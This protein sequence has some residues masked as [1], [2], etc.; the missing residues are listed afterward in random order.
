MFQIV[1]T[2]VGAASVIPVSV[3]HT[4]MADMLLIPVPVVHTDI[5]LLVLKLPAA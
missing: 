5:L 2:L 4:D 1:D 3:V